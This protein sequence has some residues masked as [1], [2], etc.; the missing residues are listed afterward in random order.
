[1]AKRRPRN[2]SKQENAQIAT[3]DKLRLLEEYLPAIEEY[4]KRG[5][6]IE[7]FLRSSTKVAYARLAALMMDSDASI[8][9]KASVEILNRSEGK[10]IERKQVLTG[11]INDLSEHQIHNELLKKLRKDPEL[12]A[13]LSEA[14]GEDLLA[15]TARPVKP[16]AKRLARSV[17]IV[18]DDEEDDNEE[19]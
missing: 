12:A 18:L 8:A 17:E 11:N 6:T 15:D 16:P 3:M 10:P 5:G 13:K 4:T 9:H 14:A 7:S 1:M 2:G 19:N